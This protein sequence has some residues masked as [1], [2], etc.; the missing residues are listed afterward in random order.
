MKFYIYICP[1]LILVL[2]G[3]SIWPIYGSYK[4]FVSG[5]YKATARLHIYGPDIFLIWIIYVNPLYG[6][7]KTL[8]GHMKFY[9]YICPKLI[10]VLYGIS[11][12]PIYGSYKEFVSGPYKATAR[13]H[14]YVQIYS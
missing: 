4:E 5:P 8:Y 2:Y 12:W 13:I 6:Q 7:H 1:K 9:M 3:I 10:L 11:I 14:I